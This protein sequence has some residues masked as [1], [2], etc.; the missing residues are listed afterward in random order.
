MNWERDVNPYCAFRGE[1]DVSTVDQNVNNTNK[2][3]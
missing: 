1:H 2:K 3:H